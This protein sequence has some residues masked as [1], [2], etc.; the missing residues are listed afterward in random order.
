VP[1]PQTRKSPGKK[2]GGW[3]G[4]GKKRVLGLEGF[5]SRKKTTI[6]AIK[7]KGFMQKGLRRDRDSRSPSFGKKKKKGVTACV[8]E[9][10]SAVRQDAGEKKTTRARSTGTLFRKK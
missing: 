3:F 7:G 4:G 10:K 1:F 2:K 9:Q 8:T 6:S 5:A